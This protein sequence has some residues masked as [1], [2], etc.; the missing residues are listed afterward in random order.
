VTADELLDA[1]EGFYRAPDSPRSLTW[2]RAEV[3]LD[4][5]ADLRLLVRDQAR[6]GLVP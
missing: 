4:A 1:V 2:W 6:A 5:I 3:V